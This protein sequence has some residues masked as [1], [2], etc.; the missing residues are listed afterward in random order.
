MGW[1]ALRLG[2]KSTRSSTKNYN[3]IH[4]KKRPTVPFSLTI[5]DLPFLIVRQ[6][7]GKNMILLIILNNNNMLLGT[8]HNYPKRNRRNHII[9]IPRLLHSFVSTG[10]FYLAQTFYLNLTADLLRPEGVSVAMYKRTVVASDWPGGCGSTDKL[11]SYEDTSTH[12]I[13]HALLELQ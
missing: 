11:T 7:D 4:F 2:F 8:Q 9:Q 3:Q 13:N 12:S 1:S 6:I 5:Q 10:F